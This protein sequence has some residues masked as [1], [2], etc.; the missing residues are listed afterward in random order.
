MNG[1]CVAQRISSKLL[2]EDEHQDLAETLSGVI[3]G[4]HSSQ[5]GFVAITFFLD[6]HPVCLLRVSGSITR[7]GIA[8]GVVNGVACRCLDR[9]R[10]GRSR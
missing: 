3:L 4:H 9:P 8:D 6:R 5:G 10:L 2:A 1:C 7:S